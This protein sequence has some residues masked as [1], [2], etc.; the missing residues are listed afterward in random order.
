VEYQVIAKMPGRLCNKAIATAAGNFR[1][2][3]ESCVTVGEAKLGM[4]M[5]GPKKRYV[6]MP[7]TYEVAVLN[8]GTVP[9]QN[10]VVDNPLPSGMTF[11]SASENG[12]FTGKQVRWN[13]GAL[14]P[15]ANQK[16]EIVLQSQN[17]GRICN[18]ATASADRGLSKQAEFCTEFAG[19]PAL[20]LVVEDSEDPV[21]IG[22][23]TAYL[24]TVRNQGSSPVTSVR[25]QATAPAQEQVADATGPAKHRIDGQKVIYD[26]VTLRAGETARY[27]VDVKAMRAGDVRFKVQLTADQLIGGPVEQQESTT[28][29]SA[30]PSSSRGSK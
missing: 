13:I 15:G 29:Y 30:L 19:M 26:P 14:A 1:E 21:E 27:R 16:L 4:T 25:I 2:E 5:T 20:S 6:N 17:T 7:A 12:Q 22:G 23:T 28:I 10:L 8:P 11:V 3:M 18:Q 24:I 9:L